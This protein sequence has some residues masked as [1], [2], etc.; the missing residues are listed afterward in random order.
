[1]GFIF[2]VLAFDGELVNLPRALSVASYV[3]LG[4]CVALTVALLRRQLRWPVLIWLGLMV[5]FVPMP[6]FDNGIIGTI[7]NLKFMFLY[8]AVIL[9]IYR[10]QLPSTSKKIWLV[11]LGLLVCAYTNVATYALCHQPLAMFVCDILVNF[12]LS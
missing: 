12:A 3:F 2:N 8:I 6:V 1:L 9:L 7:A 10:H 11:D 5:T 4:L